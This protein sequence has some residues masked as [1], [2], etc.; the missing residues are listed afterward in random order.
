MQASDPKAHGFVKKMDAI[1]VRDKYSGELI[2]EVPSIREDQVTDITKAAYEAFGRYKETFPLHKRA[3]I[4]AEATSLIRR[5][6][7]EFAKLI[8]REGGKPIK[9]SRNEAKRASLTMQFSAEEAKRVHGETIPFD[10]EPRGQNRTG[11]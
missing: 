3:E 4:L 11:Y 5:R 2:G 1:E 9:Y 10:A 6:R 8:A 7:E